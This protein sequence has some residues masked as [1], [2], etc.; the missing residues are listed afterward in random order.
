MMA[1]SKQAGQALLMFKTWMPRQFFNRFAVEQDLL[2]VG[3]KGFKGRY[4]SHSGASFA[5]LAALATVATG[6]LPGALIAG[7]LGFAAGKFIGAKNGLGLLQEL[8]HIH[9][10]L[11]RKMLGFSVNKIARKITGKNAVNIDWEN[12]YTKMQSKDFTRQDFENYKTNI[13]EM[14]Y[15]FSLLRF[16]VTY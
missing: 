16:I 11:A 1:K 15:G 7:G 3:K 6:G 2:A 4:R 5:T 10:L 8:Y 13:H 14:G 12:L 9:R